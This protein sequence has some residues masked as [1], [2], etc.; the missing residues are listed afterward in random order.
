M[1]DP[2]AQRTKKVSQSGIDEIKKLG[3]S[4]AL[5]KYTAGEGG[6][7]FKTAMERYYSPQ[8]L[9]GASTASMASKGKS[10]GTASTAPK[11]ESKPV[12]MPPSAPA[13]AKR[14]VNPAGSSVLGK[15][16]AE[17]ISSAT[18]PIGKITSAL[19]SQ[20]AVNADTV[21]KALSGAKKKFGINNPFKPRKR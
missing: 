17:A 4:A 13:A 20:R 8:R 6:A 1:P 7:E 15:K 11:T 9:K 2:D 10:G 14:K 18:K 5:K 12:P 21:G 3:M 19:A 16:N